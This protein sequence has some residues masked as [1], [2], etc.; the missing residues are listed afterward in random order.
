MTKDA[1]FGFSS[2]GDGATIK[3]MPLINMLV[4]CGDKS[5]AVIS[6]W[7]CMDH[8]VD[9]GKKDT[10]FIMNFFKLKVDEF[11]LSNV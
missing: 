6:I 7:D 9:G 2:L 10:E 8:M 5:P 3:K 1:L 4:M 11:D